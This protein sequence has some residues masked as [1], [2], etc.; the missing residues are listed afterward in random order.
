MTLPAFTSRTNL[1][2]Y[3]ISVTSK[4]VKKFI[5]NLDSSKASV[6]DCILVV[7]LMKCELELSYLLS[8]LFNMCLKE[9]CFPDSW[10][11]SNLVSVFKNVALREKCLC[12]ELFWSVFFRI[13]TEFVPE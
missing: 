2:L 6:S 1:K 12:S 3:D 4:M 7:L 8:V 10:K 11:V 9:S 13:S 5:T